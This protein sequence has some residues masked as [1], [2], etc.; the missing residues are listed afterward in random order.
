MLG[1]AELPMDL[2]QLAE[3]DGGSM[4]NVHCVLTFQGEIC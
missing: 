1:V 2:N 4:I 3:L